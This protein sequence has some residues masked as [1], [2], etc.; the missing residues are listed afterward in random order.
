MRRGASIG[1]GWWICVLYGQWYVRIGSVARI[2]TITEVIRESNFCWLSSKNGFSQSMI[3]IGDLYKQLFR[4]AK[5]SG[6]HAEITCFHEKGRD[7]VSFREIRENW[8]LKI[9]YVFLLVSG[10]FIITCNLKWMKTKWNHFNQREGFN[11]DYSKSVQD[12][13]RGNNVVSTGITT[14]TTIAVVSTNIQ[15]QIPSV[16]SSPFVTKIHQNPSRKP[17]WPIRK[18]IENKQKIWKTWFATD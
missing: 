14:T 7:C 13:T 10:F 16:K 6:R 2:I 12:C 3:L 8:I 18:G 4:E 1:S 5:E 15:S 9:T 17:I 11:S